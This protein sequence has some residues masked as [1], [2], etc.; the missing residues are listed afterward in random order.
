M[1]NLF[2]AIAGV[3]WVLEREQWPLPANNKYEKCIT[4]SI[5]SSFR[6]SNEKSVQMA[7]SPF[8]LISLDLNLNLE[9]ELWNIFN[10]KINLIF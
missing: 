4:F 3:E 8:E 2:N 7:V 9:S 5:T 6:S 10:L 1:L